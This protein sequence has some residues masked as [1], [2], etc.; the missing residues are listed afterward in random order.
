M[1][2]QPGVYPAAVTP[3]DERGKV[4]LAG[5]ARLLAYFRSE[6]CQGV[7]VS[8]S[9]GEGP[10]LSAVE[11]RDLVKAAVPLA[12]GMAVISGVATPSLEEAVWLC[13][14]SGD[15]G[16]TAALLM[17]PG[18]FREASEAGIEA[19]FTAVMDRSPIPVLVYNFPARTG[20][21]LEAPLIARLA[22][23]PRFLGLKDSSG[24]RANLSD[25]AA[26]APG[27]RLFV[28]DETLLGDAM[29]AG[30]SGTISGAANC[31]S[32]WFVAAL[33]DWESDRESA[34]AKLELVAPALKA[35]R[36][37]PQPM[38]H[39]AILRERGVL[40]SAAVRLP[41]EELDEARLTS[42]REALQTL[43]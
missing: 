23:H 16:A 21:R 10:S 9:N 18:F 6:G 26:A 36:S 17:A 8:G 42:V 37:A 34:L 33:A 30:W 28:G 11:K 12:D 14:Q 39:K 41:L 19:W 22:E 25:Y 35:L 29:A 31:L 3:F 32:R 2:L 27:K 24:E 40:P 7:V 5:V 20:V 43:E 4:D 13:R 1:S 15:A 38:A